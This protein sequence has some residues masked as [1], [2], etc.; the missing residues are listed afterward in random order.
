MRVV[1]MHKTE[2]RWEAG[3]PPSPEMIAGMGALMEDMAKSGAL[4]AAGGLRASALGVRLTF[5]D[6]ER[7]ATPGPFTP[8]NELTAGF[9]IVR[10]G[11]MDEAIGWASRVADVVGDTEIDIRPVTEPWD[12]GIVPKPPGKQTVR[13]ML[14]RKADRQ[15]EA[16]TPPAVVAGLRALTGEMK[17][18]GVLQLAEEFLPSAN[19]KR[20]N[21]VGGRQTITDGPFA[22]SKELIAGFVMVQVASLD[23]AIG[24]TTRFAAV[25]GD[26][27][28]DVR[29]LIEPALGD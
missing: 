5:K 13:F 10:V 9:S 2:P 25:T 17:R 21:V 8:V 29:P 28:V 11:S 27:E 14:I 26:V 19:G 16:A 15:S 22:E 7:T 20:I 3:Q 6:G 24:W 23:E 18:A 12:L 1:M 4:L